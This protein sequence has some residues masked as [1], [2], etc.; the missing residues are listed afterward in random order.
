[1]LAGNTLV[2]SLLLFISHTF[3]CV[4]MQVL[5]HLPALLLALLTLI[6]DST[7]YKIR[8]QAAV[9]LRALDCRELYG[10]LLPDA[11]LVVCAALESLQSS[12][13]SAYR[14]GMGETSSSSS[15]S[16]NNSIV[17]EDAGGRDAVASSSSGGRLLPEHD[18]ALEGRSTAGDDGGKFPNFR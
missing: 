16:N 3:I 10:D 14:G 12:T 1:V 4:F 11:V 6:R 17:Q 13:G 9:A 5:A 15:S 18:G 7:N 8:T 2:I